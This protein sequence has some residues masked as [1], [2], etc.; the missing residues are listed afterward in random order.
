MGVQAKTRLSGHVLDFLAMGEMAQT[1][2]FSFLLFV[3]TV[4]QQMTKL[5]APSRQRHQVK[6][7]KANHCTHQSSA[8]FTQMSS[9]K[10]V[11]WP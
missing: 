1:Q 2:I 9:L 5:A 6:N 10:E 7:S 4:H 3:L 8:T 11:V